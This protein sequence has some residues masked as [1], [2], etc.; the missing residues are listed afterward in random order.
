MTTP[1]IQQQRAEFPKAQK[2]Q[3]PPQF[4]H[5][6]P[7]LLGGSSGAAVALG[8]AELGGDGPWGSVVGEAVGRSLGAD[9]F[10]DQSPYFEDPFPP[11]FAHADGVAND[12][13]L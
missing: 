6:P 10:R 13:S 8:K 3:L 4:L 1:M 12:H 9:T 7:V 2:Q 5:V 11:G